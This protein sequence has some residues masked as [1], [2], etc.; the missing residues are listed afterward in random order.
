VVCVVLC[1]TA[2]LVDAAVNLARGGVADRV[3]LLHGD[4][5][6]APLRAASVDV[7]V[8]DL[9]FGKQH[10]TVEANRSLYPRV[11]TETARVVRPGGRAVLLTS[12]ENRDVLMAQ[13]HR[14]PACVR[15]AGL[16]FGISAG[17]TARLGLTLPT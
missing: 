17:K 2:Q 8:C 13:V 3:E 16:P 9:P 4:C 14:L 5:R 11:L 10:G 6:W 15:V 12:D 1:R 7:L